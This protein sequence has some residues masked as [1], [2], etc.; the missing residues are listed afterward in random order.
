MQ[1]R[2][3]E[4]KFL[5]SSLSEAF[6]ETKFIKLFIVPQDTL[7]KGSFKRKT[8]LMSGCLPK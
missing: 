8:I 4:N 3:E 7:E 1:G 2:E 5:I 6:L